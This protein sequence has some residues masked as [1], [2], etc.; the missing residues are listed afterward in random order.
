MTRSHIPYGHQTIDDDDVAAVASAVTSEFLTQ[1][2]AVA[3]FEAAI[4]QYCGARFAVAFANGTIALHA[5]CVAAELGPGDAGIVP[6][7]SFVATANCLAYVGAAPQFADTLPGLPLLDPDAV[8]RTI[9]SRTRAILPVHFAGATADM[10]ALRALADR[11]QCVI[12]ED[13][14]HAL[15]ARYPDA[16]GQPRV[17]ACHA[18][19]MTVFSFHPVKSLTCGEGGMV[20]TN[21]SAL[22]D[23][24]LAFRNH[25]L[26][27]TPRPHQPPWYREMRTLGYNARLSDI[28]AA[29]GRSQLRKL[30]RFIAARRACFAR[31]QVLLAACPQISLL[32]PAVPEASAHHLGVVRIAPPLARDAVFDALTNQGIGVQL[33]YMPIYRHPY[34]QERGLGN[35]ADCPQ[36]EAYF[37]TALTIPLY[38]T[39]SQDDQER[40]VALLRAA[41]TDAPAR[42]RKAHTP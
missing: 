5:T 33:H 10:A 27:A 29:L 8:A 30:D 12:I 7:I 38:P 37:A 25:G 21:N 11:H 4:A 20:T 19:D 24:L 42:Q 40:V 35:P 22:R 31:Y 41:C 36:A 2:P 23:R 9:T 15:G 17:G 13:A 14:C 28:H 26:T 3:D 16:P 18:S 32:T 34:Y 1:G 39:L 6:A